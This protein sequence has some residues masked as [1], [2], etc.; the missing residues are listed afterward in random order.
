[1]TM[2]NKRPILRSMLPNPP[3]AVVATIPPSDLGVYGGVFPPQETAR[4][5]SVACQMATYLTYQLDQSIAEV[6]A[7]VAALVAMSLDNDIPGKNPKIKAL[8]VA[9]LAT[10][11]G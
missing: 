4:I 11:C 5:R 3:Y 6:T 1:M 8:I 10:W 9:N 2:R 7:M